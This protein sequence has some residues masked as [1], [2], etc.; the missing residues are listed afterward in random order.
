MTILSVGTPRSGAAQGIRFLIIGAAAVICMAGVYY[1]RD[2]VSPVFLAIT[3]VLTARPMVRWL[4][5]RG[6]PRVLST[7]I[8]MIAIFAVLLA[9]LLAV[10]YA[11]LQFATEIPQFADQ[12]QTLY[13]HATAWLTSLGISPQASSSFLANF[14]FT[15]LLGFVTGLLS[16][17][18][19]V[20]TFFFTLLLFVAFVAIDLIDT[21]E[22]GAALTATQP[23]LGAALVDF[24]WRVRQYWLVNTIFALAVAIIDVAILSWLHVPL[25]LTW[26]ILSFVTSYIPNIG[27]IIGMVPPAIIALLDQGWETMVLLLISYTAVNFT[28]DMLIQPKVTGDA[29]GLNITAT[30]VSL[31]FWSLLLGPM[32]AILAVPLTL[33]FK[34]ILLDTESRTRWMSIFLGGDLDGLAPGPAAPPD[35]ASPEPDDGAALRTDKTD[36]PDPAPADESA[37]DPDP[38]PDEPNHP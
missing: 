7:F 25:V 34:C 16:G 23:R 20:G 28:S 1:T 24:S 2:I 9:I 8:G 35:D 26:G 11:L 14:D 17:I 19:G 12:V 38:G 22:R 21:T 27:F 5:S 30:F 37:A 6:V 15:R 10:S 31:L 13:S 18:A 33:F 29:V 4:N 36:P 3:L 32:G